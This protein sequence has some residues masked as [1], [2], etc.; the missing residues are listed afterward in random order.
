MPTGVK[1]SGAWKDLSSLG[2]KVGGA[3]KVAS[4][5]IKVSGVWKQFFAVG[6]GGGGTPN[7]I[8]GSLSA[9]ASTLTVTSAVCDLTVAL[10]NTGQVQV[11][12]LIEGSGTTQIKIGSG[13]F[14]TVSDNDILT[15]PSSDFITARGVGMTSSTTIVFDLYDVDT[16]TLIQSVIIERT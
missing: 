2:V 6:G 12:N 15:W 1:V 11:R 10:G 4:G 5:H 7:S 3:W 13:S 16:N 9:T 8:V 14:T